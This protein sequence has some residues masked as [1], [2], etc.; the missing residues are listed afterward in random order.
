MT[1]KLRNHGWTDAEI[2]EIVAAVALMRYTSTVASALDVPLE[3]AM[4]GVG[5][6]CGVPLN[7]LES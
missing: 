3:K 5:V 1:D 6:S 7:R 2:V 4:E